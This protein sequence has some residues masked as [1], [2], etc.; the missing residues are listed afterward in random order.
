MAEKDAV[1][2]G[3]K[4]T[5]PGRVLYPEQGITKRDL[6]RYYQRVADWILPHL[7]GRPLTLVRCPGG[8]TKQ[9]FYQRHPRDDASAA[10]ESIIAREKGKAVNFF[11]VDS[12][13]G[14][15][16]L[17]QMGTLE[18]HTWGSRAPRL[19]RPDRMIF[20]LDPGPGV[21][22]KQ[23]TAGAALLRA[24]LEALDLGAFVKTTGGKGLHVVVPIAPNQSWEFVKTFSRALA[25]SMVRDDPDRYLATMSKAKRRGKIFIDYLRNNRT[26]T[27]VCAYSTRARAG[28]PVSMPVRW[29]EL[30]KDLRD[31][32][33]IR[34]APQR[35]AQRSRDAWSDYESARRPL[36]IKL[37]RQIE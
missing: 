8:R 32:F 19:D 12:L 37:L 25:D 29:E 7:Q 4:L 34:N 24:R 27:A 14:L 6:A 11:S 13:S 10:V 31:D 9:C 21:D 17:V 35:I 30:Q 28:A 3:I 16:A 20:D 26:A 23:L 33:T 5:H 1:V 15:I 18:L 2:A 36:T 22:W